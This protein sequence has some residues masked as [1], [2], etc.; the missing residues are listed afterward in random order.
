[1]RK[2]KIIIPIVLL[3][4]LF[5]ISFILQSKYNSL[6]MEQVNAE[7]AESFITKQIMFFGSSFVFLNILITTIV[8]C[9]VVIFVILV[10][11]LVNRTKM[12]K[13][14]KSKA[15]LTVTYQSLILD[16][17]D[18][19][20][21]IDEKKFKKICHN[22]FRKNI[23]ID[24]I[25]DVAVMMPKELL[26]HLRQLYFDLKLIEETERKLNSSKW[27]NKIKAMKELSHLEIKDYN[28]DILKLINA[29]ND[30]LRMEAQ[31]AMVRLSNAD[32]PFEFMEHLEHDFSTWEQITLHEAM[33]AADIQPPDF[34]RWL[35]SDNHDVGMFC[36][37]MLREYKQIDVEGLEM[38]L[39]HPNEKV[40][41]FAIEIV[42]DLEVTELTGIL[43]KI[44]K[45]EPYQNGLEI[46]KTLGK[47]KNPKAIKFL[48]HVVDSEEDTQLQ[49]EG[50][51]AI[52]YCGDEGAIA[53]QKML[54][55]DYKDYNIIIKHVIDKR[56]N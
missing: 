54:T 37:R 40:A 41:R 9:F 24:Q 34:G 56:I 27:H 33:I 38:M 39:Y 12:E 17:L 35:I 51:K 21:L 1:M 7:T 36:L 53:L 11:V 43:K 13:R 44:Y 16:Y 6:I 19:N 15:E 29:K 4:I 31:I 50:V 47:L 23:L 45:D 20:I 48:Q 18:D 3:A 55:S 49:I 30:T 28:D 10:S 26:E 5:A 22:R 2:L 8:A 25:I 32:N 14:A 52:N 46:V 42:G